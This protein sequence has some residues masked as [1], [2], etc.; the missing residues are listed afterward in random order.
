MNQKSLIRAL[1]SN[2]SALKKVVGKP[3]IQE[4]S[5]LATNVFIGCCQAVTQSGCAPRAWIT[6]KPER[7]KT[8]RK[9][10]RK[11]RFR[12]G[13]VILCDFVEYTISCV[14]ACTW[15]K[16]FTHGALPAPEPTIRTKAHI[17]AMHTGRAAHREK[18]SDRKAKRREYDAKRRKEQRINA[19]KA[20]EEIARLKRLFG[21]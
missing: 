7:L 20:A 1:K 12:P 21:R 18:E 15:M 13:N 2:I 16:D 9:I 4:N 5:D 14:E 8:L 11:Y 6:R 17:A 3:F 10:G 19:N